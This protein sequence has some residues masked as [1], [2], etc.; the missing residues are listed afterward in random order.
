MLIH[1]TFKF[2]KITHLPKNKAPILN[3]NSATLIFLKLV[4]GRP[5]PIISKDVENTYLYYYCA[6]GF[7]GY[8]RG[9]GGLAAP[10]VKHWIASQRKILTLN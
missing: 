6:E 2:S 8:S 4:K 5:I 7:L 10:H 9:G 1:M 3:L